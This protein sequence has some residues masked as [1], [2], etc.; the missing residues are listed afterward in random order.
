MKYQLVQKT[1]AVQYKAK[2][3]SAGKVLS[4]IDKCIAKCKNS[5]DY[6]SAIMSKLVARIM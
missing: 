4:E 6:L 5:I 2:S 1:E 3:D